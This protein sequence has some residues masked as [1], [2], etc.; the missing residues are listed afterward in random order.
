M[1]TTPLVIYGLTQPKIL[2]S[3]D[4]SRVITYT[5]DSPT[6]NELNWGEGTGDEMCLGVYY[7]TE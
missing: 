1:F 2:E 4:D 5:Y 7:V 3:G 6:A